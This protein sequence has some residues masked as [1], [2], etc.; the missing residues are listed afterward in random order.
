MAEAWRR[1]EQREAETPWDGGSGAYCIVDKLIELQL[2]QSDGK[3]FPVDDGCRYVVGLGK[4]LYNVLVFLVEEYMDAHEPLP[5]L[6]K[7][8]AAIGRGGWQLL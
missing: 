2:F 6:K 7:T 8:H 1:H 3:R 4:L 5:F